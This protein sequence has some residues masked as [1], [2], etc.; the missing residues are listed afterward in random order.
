MMMNY[1]EFIDRPQTIS[2]LG[3]SKVTSA[4]EETIELQDCLDD[5]TMADLQRSLLGHL[6]GPV[7]EI[8]SGFGLNLAYYP[9]T[10][11]R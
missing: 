1:I 8:G 3:M 11:D 9:K 5:A 6:Q 2:R 10:I 7:L 4:K